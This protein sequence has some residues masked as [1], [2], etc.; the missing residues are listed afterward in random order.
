MTA[1]RWRE[2][3]G[4]GS[5]RGAGRGAGGC[6]GAGVDRNALSSPGLGAGRGQRLPG[7]AA[8]GLARALRGRAGAGAGLHARLGRAGGATSCCVR[9]RGRWLVA[10]PRVAAAPGDV[11]LFRM[12]AGSRGQASGHRRRDRRRADVHSCLLRAWRWSKARFPRRGSAASWRGSNFR[13]EASDGND[14]TVGGRGGCRIG[15]SAARCWGCRAAVIGRAVGA[16]LGRVIDQR[17]LGRGSQAVE[18]GRVDRF[19]LTGASEGA[20]VAPGRGAR[21]GLAGR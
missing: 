10:K 20:P 19:R 12:R 21:C 4:R 2:R 9:R 1:G 18:T 14:C 17:L 13:R 8:R 3:A 5:G 11:L 7:A 15:G 6:T 16:T